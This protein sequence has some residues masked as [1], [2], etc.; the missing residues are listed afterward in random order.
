MPTEREAEMTPKTILDKI[1]A[2]CKDIEKPTRQAIKKA[3]AEHYDCTN[4]AAL[5]W[6]N[7]GIKKALLQGVKTGKLFQEGQTFYTEPKPEFEPEPETWTPLHP[8]KKHYPESLDFHGHSIRSSNT[9]MDFP[10]KYH[11]KEIRKADNHSFWKFAFHLQELCHLYKETGDHNRADGFQIA[12]DNMLDLS[13]YDCEHKDKYGNYIGIGEEDMLTNMLPEDVKCL[14]D[15]YG[16]GVSTVKL[17]EEW[18]ETGTMKR[19]EDMRKEATPSITER[20]RYTL[21]SKDKVEAFEAKHD[22]IPDFLKALG[23]LADLYEKEGMRGTGDENQRRAFFRATTFHR[24]I[25]ALEGQIITA[26]EDIKL[27]KLIELKGVRKA[28][29]E[30]FKEFIETGKIKKLEE[31]RLE[32][33]LKPNLSNSS[34]YA[35]KANFLMNM[36]G[37][38]TEHECE[39]MYNDWS[40]CL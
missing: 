11:L 5:R 31:K 10:N 26:V 21:N 32:K 9:S 35:K 39:A 20:V 4:E 24:A 22:Y 40:E 23:E 36:F 6:L 28:T 8:D 12:L 13:N 37:D 27:F 1:V 30:L 3:L 17:I 29:L 16:V 38:M 25:I 15:I 19:L 33:A 18:I 14:R 2:L 7:S 34:T